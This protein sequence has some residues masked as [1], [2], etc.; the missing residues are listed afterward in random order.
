M[1]VLRGWLLRVE[2]F[3]DLVTQANPVGTV[4]IGSGILRKPTQK[5][6]E[7]HRGEGG[8]ADVD[9][10]GCLPHCFLWLV[11][12]EFVQVAAYSRTQC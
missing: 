8:W 11:V 2:R 6:E 7:V 4:I 12:L 9:G 1:T 3:N 5:T 10:L